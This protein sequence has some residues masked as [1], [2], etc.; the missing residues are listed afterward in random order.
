[1]D[2][3]EKQFEFLLSKQF[4][5]V[6]KKFDTYYIH[7]G[8]EKQIVI[9]FKNVFIFVTGNPYYATEIKKL[10]I[11]FFSILSEKENNRF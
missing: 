3:M 6:T 9:K 7:K 4:K 2:E 11:D 10:L 8:T 5:K 1:M